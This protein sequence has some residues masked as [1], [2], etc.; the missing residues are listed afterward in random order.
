MFL[1]SVNGSVVCLGAGFNPHGRLYYCSANPHSPFLSILKPSVLV[2]FI[3][4]G[5]VHGSC[6]EQTDDC[7]A[8]PNRSSRDTVLGVTRVSASPG[9]PA[10]CHE[11]SLGALIADK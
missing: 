6:F 5:L 11:E 2:H 1:I 10:I 8:V 4:F 7:M 9:A 3:D